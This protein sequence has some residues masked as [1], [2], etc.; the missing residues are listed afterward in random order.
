MDKSWYFTEITVG[1]RTYK[2]QDLIKLFVARKIVYQTT[3]T[4]SYGLV[5]YLPK[6]YVE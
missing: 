2:S 5:Y 3:Y 6:Q 4:Y 1:D